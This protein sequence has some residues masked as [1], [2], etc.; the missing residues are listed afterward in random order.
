MTLTQ[1]GIKYAVHIITSNF[2]NLVAK[3][4]ESLL[5]RGHLSL[6]QL[7]GFTELTPQQVKNSLLILIQHN[8]VQPFSFDQS[9]G[10]KVTQYIALFDN[11]IHRGRFA[12][13]LAVVS[14]ELDTDHELI[15]K[16]LLENGRLTLKQIIEGAESSK[17]QG[18][19]A[20][21]DSVQESF[22][23]LVNAHFVERCPAP[24]P[25]LEQATKQEGPAKKRG[26][27]SAKMVEVPETIEQRVIALAAPP[28]AVR[29]SIM[30]DSEADAPGGKSD[31][32]SVGEKRKHPT[33]EF[34]TEFGSNDE[35]VLW[36]ANF[37][38]FIRCL[39][40]KACIENVRAR[41][42]DE[43][44][45]VLRAMLKATRT[46]EK[47]VKTE[48]SVPLSLNTIYEE[49]INSEA[50]R[51][52]TMGRVRDSLSGLCDSSQ[53]RDVDEDESYSA[54]L[55][56][57]LEL[58]QDDEV[59]SIVLKRYGKD[60]YTMFRILSLAGRPIETD[61]ISDM[62]QLS[63]VE[64]N[65][66]PKILYNLWKDDYLHMERLVVTGARQSQFLVWRVDKPIIWKH[67]LDEMF[68]TALNLSLRLACEEERFKEIT[69]LPAHKLLGEMAKQWQLYRNVI[70]VLQA[71]LLKL[72]DALMLFHD[73]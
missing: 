4:C 34:D 30:I 29:F 17:S 38:E 52:L 18:D 11:I 5:R 63:L 28:E 72:D 27:K 24:E 16:D 1:Y 21:K 20:G 68:H 41:L 71:S 39:R 45:V 26:A 3:V 53:E 6:K 43:A 33:L 67:V 69:D 14:Q 65:E 40:H 62:S 9:E 57:I 8:C 60:A 7:I 64:K 47:K 50:G 42:D 19:S 73:F 15:L 35:V 13:F 51:S 12:K 25:V 66:T 32:M 61:K 23:K 59:E 70:L 49:V 54:D 31:N 58:A 55:K 44:A 37:E 56:K 46:A 10:P 48:N 2:G 22:L 36:R